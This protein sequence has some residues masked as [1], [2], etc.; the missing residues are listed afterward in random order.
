[1]YVICINNL[2]STKLKYKMVYKVN[3]I[4]DNSTYRITIDGREYSYQKRRFK[5][6][7]NQVRKDIIKKL[8]EI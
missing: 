3:R 6:V 7:T 2:G 8:I 4:N 1:M 5:I